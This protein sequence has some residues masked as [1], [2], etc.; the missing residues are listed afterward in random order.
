MCQR[1]HGMMRNISLKVQI[2]SDVANIATHMKSL[3]FL[4]GTIVSGVVLLIV[5][6]M[7]T[8]GVV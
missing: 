6:L 8:K 2:D 3:R 4:V 5:H 7:E 1:A